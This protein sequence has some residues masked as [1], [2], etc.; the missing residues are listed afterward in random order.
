MASDYTRYVMGRIVWGLEVLFLWLEDR[1]GEGGGSVT[2]VVLQVYFR[3]HSRSL[4]NPNMNTHSD[5]MNYHSGFPIGST[6]R[7]C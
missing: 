4:N 2:S 3:D 1:P 5:I 7:I 6:F